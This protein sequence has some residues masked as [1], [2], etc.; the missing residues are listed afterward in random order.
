MQIAEKV[1]IRGTYGTVMNIY[2]STT[3]PVA[4]AEHVRN[5]EKF[6]THTLQIYARNNTAEFSFNYELLKSSN[7]GWENRA[8][9]PCHR[10][11]PSN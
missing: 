11:R 2:E 6:P 3:R 5:L 9:A 4:S 7:W 1:A 10:H 8:S